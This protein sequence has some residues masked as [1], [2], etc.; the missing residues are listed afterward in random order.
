MLRTKEVLRL[1]AAN[2]SPP[3]SSR[4]IALSSL[5]ASPPPGTV[6]YPGLPAPLSEGEIKHCDPAGSSLL[7]CSQ[8][9]SW[10]KAV[11]FEITGEQ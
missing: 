6:A 3:P 4:Q 1:L 11:L 5:A 2:L 7:I 8:M 9:R 10:Q